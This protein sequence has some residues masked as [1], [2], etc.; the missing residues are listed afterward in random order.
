MWY[1][2]AST[3]RSK[4]DTTWKWQLKHIRQILTVFIRQ[5]MFLGIWFHCTQSYL[6]PRQSFLNT[7]EWRYDTVQYKMMLHTSLQWLRESLN[8][9][10]NERAMAFVLWG[11]GIKLTALYTTAPHYINDRLCVMIHVYVLSH[12]TDPLTKWHSALDKQIPSEYSGYRL[13][14]TIWAPFQYPIKRLIVRSRKLSGPRD[15]YLELRVR[16]EIW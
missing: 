2:S 9:Q 5:R 11:F 10:N 13:E 1:L 7:V 6:H 3:S 12:H 14:W 8:S 16:I 15:L 4:I